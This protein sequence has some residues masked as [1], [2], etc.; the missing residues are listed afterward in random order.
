MKN[1]LLILFLVLLLLPI[2]AFGQGCG[3]QTRLVTLPY[4]LN[5]DS[6]EWVA[7]LACN[8]CGGT[9]THATSGCYSGGC[10]KVLPPTSGCASGNGGGV[11]LGW[12]TY[13]SQSEVHVRFL[14]K[15][16]P[17][18][19]A[20][21]MTSGLTKFLLFDGGGRSGIMGL[22]GKSEGY[23]GW[24]AADIDTGVYH[25]DLDEAWP[26]CYD[27]AEGIRMND[28]LLNGVWIA[29]EYYVSNARN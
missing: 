23:M 18:F 26:D 6:D 10:M 28:T 12:I 17:T 14:I 24:A 2:N 3:E 13:S 29:V 7:D 27:V 4:S 15:F 11:G 9:S 19:F 1:G 16:G 5:F 22:I 25:F 8:D 20:N 21:K